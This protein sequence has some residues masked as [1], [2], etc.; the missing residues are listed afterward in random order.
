[1]DWNH[2]RFR[3]LWPLPAPAPDVYRALERIEDYPRWW[4]QVREV[5]RIDDTTGVIRVRS[6]LPYDLRTTVREGR[7]DPAAGVLEVAMSGDMEGW[8]RWTVAPR[9]SGTVVR[10]DQEVVVGKPLLRRLAVPGRPLFRANH[11]L[12]M[13]AGRRGLAAHLNAV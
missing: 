13:R 5:T 3:S 2:Y 12:M 11:R 10:Y 6:L 8:A 1:M 4:H 9:G 7:R